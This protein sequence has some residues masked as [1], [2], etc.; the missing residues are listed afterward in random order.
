VFSAAENLYNW[1]KIRCAVLTQRA[2]NILRKGLAF[3]DIATDLADKAFLASGFRL[4]LNIILIVSVCH[5]VLVGKHA[6]LC[7]AAD[8]HSVRIQVYILLDLKGHK[9]IDVTGQE[10]KPVI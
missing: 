5:S 2:Y 9:G 1:L 4:G 8:K 3:I 6:S 10:H 7:D